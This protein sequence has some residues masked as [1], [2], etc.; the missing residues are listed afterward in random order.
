MHAYTRPLNSTHVRCQGVN[1]APCGRVCLPSV[2][3][4]SMHFDGKGVG[5]LQVPAVLGRGNFV[6]PVC[7]CMCVCRVCVEGCVCVQGVAV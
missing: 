3:E 7:V 6:R 5:D 2:P 4:R 1:H